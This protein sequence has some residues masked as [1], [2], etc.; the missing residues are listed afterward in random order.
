MRQTRWQKSGNRG[1][2][3]VGVF[4]P[5]C[6]SSAAAPAEPQAGWGVGTRL[7]HRGACEVWHR[8]ESV[9]GSV[10]L[11]PSRDLVMKKLLDR[12]QRN[13]GVSLASWLSIP[14]ALAPATA[15]ILLRPVTARAFRNMDEYLILTS[16]SIQRGVAILIQRRGSGLQGSKGNL[17]DR[18][19][20]PADDPHRAGNSLMHHDTRACRGKGQTIHRDP[21]LAAIFCRNQY[22]GEPAD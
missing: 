17:R 20:C 15:P 14:P 11:A 10:S 21:G 1:R 16:T 7:A 3:P 18:N 6:A 12:V 19:S 5:A 8:R 2:P 4:N 9:P 13:W 22:P